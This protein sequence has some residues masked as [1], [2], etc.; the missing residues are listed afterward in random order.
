MSVCGEMPSPLVSRIH[1]GRPSIPMT[2]S[3]PGPDATYAKCSV[4]FATA[5]RLA[6]NTCA[7]SACRSARGSRMTARGDGLIVCATEAATINAGASA[8]TRAILP[9][10]DSADTST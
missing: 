1:A 10:A 6:I 4:R 9:P 5:S 2:T 7:I 3:G 8:F